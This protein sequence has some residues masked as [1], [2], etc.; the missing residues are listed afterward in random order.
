MRHEFTFVFLF[1]PLIHK[2]KKQKFKIRVR[3]ENSRRYRGKRE[4]IIFMDEKNL[5]IFYFGNKKKVQNFEY[6]KF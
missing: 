5:R 3:G 4:L 1:S 2:L 6:G